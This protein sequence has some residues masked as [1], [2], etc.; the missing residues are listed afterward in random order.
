[1]FLLIPRNKAAVSFQRNKESVWDVSEDARNHHCCL[2]DGLV[3]LFSISFFVHEIPVDKITRID[4]AF[5]NV[6]PN[7][8]LVLGG[9]WADTDRVFTDDR[10][11][12]S[13]RGNSYQLFKLIQKYP[14]LRTLISVGGWV[15]SSIYCCLKPSVL[16]WLV[17]MVRS[18]LWCDAE[19]A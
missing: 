9:P 2:L 4:Y 6:G 13:L 10:W 8:R 14:H 15:T 12:Q 7:G 18:I 16:V 19:S 1:M 17:D 3:A 5:A 11:D